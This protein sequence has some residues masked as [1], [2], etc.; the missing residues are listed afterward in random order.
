MN[1]IW[2]IIPLFIWGSD[3]ITNLE[4]GKMLYKNPRGIGC[5]KCHS[6]DAKGAV[7]ATYYDSNAQKKELIAPNIQNVTWKTF[8]LRVKLSEK[9][10]NNKRKKINFCAMPKYNYLLDDEIRSIYNYIKSLNKERE[11]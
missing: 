4:Y 10:K 2:I 3:F 1:K 11:L 5:I 7:I 9:I 8:Y 6:K